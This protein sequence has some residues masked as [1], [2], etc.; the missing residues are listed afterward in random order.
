M[1][2]SGRLLS[3]SIKYGDKNGLGP[4]L[5]DVLAAYEKLPE[6]ERRPYSINTV[7]LTNFADT[8]SRP[9]CARN[10]GPADQ[11]R[12]RVTEGNQQ[13]TR[14]RDGLTRASKPMPCGWPDDQPPALFGRAEAVNREG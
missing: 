9:L 7:D 3:G 11:L 5:N 14:Q 13:L 8:T 1:T 2:A 12:I 10:S 6:A 4:A